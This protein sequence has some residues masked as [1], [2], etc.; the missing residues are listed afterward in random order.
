MAYKLRDFAVQVRNGGFIV[1][2]TLENGNIDA[3]QA[4]DK[5]DQYIVT[6][7]AKLLKAFKDE[8]KD[9]QPARK[10]RAKK[11]TA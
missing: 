7:Y 9:F 3:N 6:S 4:D 5:Y 10:P 2:V 11:E 1:N 8:F